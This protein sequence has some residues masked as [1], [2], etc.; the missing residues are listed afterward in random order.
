[1]TDL[2]RSEEIKLAE[3]QR[4]VDDK[5]A[6][7]LDDEKN[8]KIQQAAEIADAITTYY[9]KKADERIAKLNEEINAAK[10][11][12]TFLQQLAAEGN[13]NAQ[14]SLAEQ[15][16]IIAEANRKKEQEEQR[17]QRAELVNAA[18]QTYAAKAQDPNVE[19]PLLETIRDIALLQQFIATIPAFLDGTEDTG[20]NGQGVD[21]KGGF[22]AILHP[23]ERVMTKE[24]NAKVG[25]LSNANL[26]KV[27]QEYNAGKLVSANNAMQ[28]GGAW[29]STAVLNELS[30]IQETI[31]NKPE[32]NIRLEEIK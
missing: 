27:A 31:K 1:M 15:N 19:N 25:N 11:Q 30:A 26:A 21:G 6:A 16:R 8:K 2:I 22:N 10:Q 5:E 23:N 4:Q 13:I 24:Q 3:M 7:A 28:I 9:I 14:Q 20:T 18:L 17:K 29:E 32:T 12:A